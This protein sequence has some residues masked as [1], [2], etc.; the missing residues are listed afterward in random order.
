MNNPPLK[1]LFNAVAVSST[2]VYYSDWVES[3]DSALPPSVQLSWTGTPTGAVEIHFSNDAII[4]YEKERIVGQASNGTQGQ[5]VARGASSAARFVVAN[6]DNFL[7][8]PT[9][10]DP[11]GG[12]GTQFINFYIRPKWFRIKYTNASSSGTLDGWA[13]T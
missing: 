13:S 5:T 7:A 1:I 12:A 10:A 8:N 4:Q 11:A 9:G 2:T 3:S 6:A